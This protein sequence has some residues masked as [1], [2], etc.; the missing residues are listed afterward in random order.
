M[1]EITHASVNAT[2]AQMASGVMLSG[3]TARP[4]LLIC[5]EPARVFALALQYSQRMGSESPGPAAIHGKFA[6]QPLRFSPITVIRL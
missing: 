1:I 3:R 4:E 5:P 6:R 2:A